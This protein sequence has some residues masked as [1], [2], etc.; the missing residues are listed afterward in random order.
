VGGREG[1]EEG[2]AIL[3]EQ[4]QMKMYMKGWRYDSLFCG[5]C[6]GNKGV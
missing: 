5:Q 6:I 4:I 1:R 2:L 3:G